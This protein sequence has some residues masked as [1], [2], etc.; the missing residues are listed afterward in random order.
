MT[1]AVDLLDCAA[2]HEAVA[3]VAPLRIDSEPQTFL[4]FKIPE[5]RFATIVAAAST[6][7]RVA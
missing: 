5:R 4:A 3:L 7:Q 6:G 1:I 2:D